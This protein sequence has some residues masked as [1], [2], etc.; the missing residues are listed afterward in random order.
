MRWDGHR[1][2]TDIDLLIGADAVTTLWEMV[3]GPRLAEL[4]ERLGRRGWTLLADRRNAWSRVYGHETGEGRIDLLQNEPRPTT[5]RTLERVEGEEIWC[6]STEQVLA[7]KLIG[8]GSAAPV[9][10]LYDMAVAHTADAA[11]AGTGPRRGRDAATRGNAEGMARSGASVRGPGAGGDQGGKGRG[12]RGAAG[13]GGRDRV[14][15]VL[16]ADLSG[17]AGR[18]RMENYGTGAWARSES[19]VDGG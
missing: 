14:C 6:L 18:G 5:G 4:D 7:G 1:E 10:D 8:R 11:G 19:G 15:E 3:D 12:H 2:S 16:D 13:G 17:L 9:R